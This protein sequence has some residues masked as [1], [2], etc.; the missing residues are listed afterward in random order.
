MSYSNECGV[1]DVQ[2][3]G[4]FDVETLGLLVEESENTFKVAQ[5]VWRD[6]DSIHCFHHVVVIPKFAVEYVKVL[7]PVQEIFKNANL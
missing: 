4:Y 7:T 1:S 3:F 6:N 5:Q 2:G